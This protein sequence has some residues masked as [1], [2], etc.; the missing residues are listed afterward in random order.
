MEGW[1]L[2]YFSFFLGSMAK[3]I[4]FAQRMRGLKGFSTTV[5][6]ESTVVDK[7]EMLLWPM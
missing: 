5:F 4:N 6:S 3:T 2:C 1:S 7:E